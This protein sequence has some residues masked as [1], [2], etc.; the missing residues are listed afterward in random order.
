[1]RI[2]F[3][4]TYRGETVN[5]DETSSQMVVSFTLYDGNFPNGG[6]GAVSSV[7]GKT[8][9]VVLDASDIAE[10]S[11][12]KWLTSTL[13]GYY[14]TAYNWVNTNGSSVLQSISDLQTAIGNRY[15]KSE[16]DNLL[17]NKVDK[18]SGK[19][20]SENDLTNALKSSYD[21]AVTDK[22]THGNKSI[23]DL[24][25]Q[26]LTTALKATYDGYG[27]QISEKANITEVETILFKSTTSTIVTGKT[28]ET[29]IYSIPLPTDGNNY[30]IEVYSQAQVSTFAGNGIYHRLRVG[31]YLSPIE[32]STGAN[33]IG[34]QT[35]IGMNAISSAN[36]MQLTRR[37]IFRGGASGSIYG[38][39]AGVS[40]ADDASGSVAFATL[41][42]ADFTTQNYL[43]V[44][45]N[46]S[47]TSA[48]VSHS[49][50][51]VKLIKI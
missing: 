36:Q 37:F 17:N 16:T 50:I 21:S 43:Y 22:H 14:D 11:T 19:G 32:G 13:K 46:P 48:V 10:T 2:D 51:I 29:S 23:L 6:S 26:P 27:S 4:I 20:L 15:T 39:G 24:I 49:M 18:V 33:A 7:N 31:T 5:L 30:R 25:E 42:S 3:E 8:G 44:S 38:G 41:K 28:L 1:M 12:L 35:T 9:A 45:F 47:N 34:N 40:Y